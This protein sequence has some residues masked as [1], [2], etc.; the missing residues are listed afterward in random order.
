IFH[1]LDRHEPITKTRD[2]IH[3]CFAR[4]AE[5]RSLTAADAS[6]HTKTECDR[7]RG[8]GDY[9]YI[10][11]RWALKTAGR[12]SDGIRLGWRSGFDSGLSLDYVYENRPRGITVVGRLIDR[13]YLNSIGWRGIRQ[14][15]INLEHMLRTT[16][17]RIHAEGRPAH[18]L[19]VA[20]GPGRYVLETIRSVASE[21]SPPMTALLRDSREENLDA[22]RS[23]AARLGLPG[24]DFEIGDAFDRAGLAALRPR[25][26]I[27][28]VSGLYELVPENGPV[29]TSLRG[30]ADLVEPGGYLVY[31]NQ[32]WH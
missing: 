16:I 27:V 32:P 17:R 18:L 22:A 7:L 21:S 15:R 13:L 6:G 2:F 28:I 11:M 19:D 26:T 31:T 30:L 3:A 9:R 8:Q 1:E 24:V 23:I 14:R 5:R 25:P 29:L 10:P 20:S 12:L 4:S